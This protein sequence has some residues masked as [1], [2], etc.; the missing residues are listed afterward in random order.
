MP[1]H[2]NDH[3]FA[4]WEFGLVHWLG[5]WAVELLFW[6]VIICMIIIVANWIFKNNE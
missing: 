4:H 6:V 1:Q 3:F 2:H 5:H